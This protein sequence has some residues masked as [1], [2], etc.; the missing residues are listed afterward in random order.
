M[1]IMNITNA[2]YGASK[3]QE[4]L[5]LK[6]KDAITQINAVNKA[7]E[8]DEFNRINFPNSYNT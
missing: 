1:K 2:S 4:P 3:N 8:I 7:A 5:K 6:M